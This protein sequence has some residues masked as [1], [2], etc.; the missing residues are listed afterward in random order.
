MCLRKLYNDNQHFTAATSIIWTCNPM[1][2]YLHLQFAVW[3]QTNHGISLLCVLSR[4]MNRTYGGQ[5]VIT[6]RIIVW[7]FR[8]FVIKKKYQRGSMLKNG[9]VH[10]K[11]RT[12][13]T[14]KA[15]HR[16]SIRSKLSDNCPNIWTQFLDSVHERTRTMWKRCTF[17]R[18][19]LKISGHLHRNT[20]SISRQRLWKNKENVHWKSSELSRSSFKISGQLSWYLDQISK[21]LPWKNKDNVL[22]KSYILSNNWGLK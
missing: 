12:F 20:D 1:L 2:P 10:E 5:S 22:W 15:R 17:S 21:Q 18:N 9:H 6:F 7:N 14:G 3:F 11:T 4:T 19:L 8:L 13:S 16:P